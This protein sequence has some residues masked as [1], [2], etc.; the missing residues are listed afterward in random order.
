MNAIGYLDKINGTNF[1]EGY[2]PKWKTFI[3]DKP[4]HSI[5]VDGFEKQIDPQGLTDLLEFLTFKGKFLPLP[6]NK[7]ATAISTKGLFQY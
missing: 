6:M 1:M 3:A 2:M 4:N 5:Q 7:A